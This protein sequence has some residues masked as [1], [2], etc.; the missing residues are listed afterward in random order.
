[1]FKGDIFAGLADS[2]TTRC[3]P[4]PAGDY[5]F[6]CTVHPNMAGTLTAE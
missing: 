4:W 6:I 2:A 3:R 1:M 5:E